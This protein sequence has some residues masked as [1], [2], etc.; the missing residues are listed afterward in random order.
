MKLRIA[1]A[2]VG[3]AV[4]SMAPSR[5]HENNLDHIGAYNFLVEI[6]G[7]AAGHFQNVSGLTDVLEGS[8]TQSTADGDI[9]F[10]SGDTRG[11]GLQQGFVGSA[12]IAVSLARPLGDLPAGHVCAISLPVRVERVNRRQL[13][14]RPLGPATDDCDALRR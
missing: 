2:V 5:R 3:L 1:V 4:L 12:T 8:G 7:V 6:S 11:K 10:R 14:L 9:R 13:R